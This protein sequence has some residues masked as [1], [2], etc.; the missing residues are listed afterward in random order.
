MYRAYLMFGLL[1]L[2]TMT[3]ADYRGLSFARY[4]AVKN[5]PRDIRNNPGAYRGIYQRTYFHK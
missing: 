2:G 3:F 1:A 5:V 4:D